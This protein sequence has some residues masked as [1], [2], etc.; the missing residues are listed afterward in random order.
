MK[1]KTFTTETVKE[2]V[3]L[4]DPNVKADRKCC[5][6]LGIV[7]KSRNL[8]LHDVYAH[9]LGHVPWSIATPYGTLQKPMKSLLLDISEKDVVPMTCAPLRAVMINDKFANIQT[10][11][12]PLLSGFDN[13]DNCK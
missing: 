10:L 12:Q 7:A 3:K 13:C 6:K 2:S 1:L 11:T 8:K 9:E 5:C 4:K